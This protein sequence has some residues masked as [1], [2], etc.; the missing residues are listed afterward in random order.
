MRRCAYVLVPLLISSSALGDSRRNCGK[1]TGDAEVAACNEAIR[2]NPRDAISY[3]NL[4][5][6]HYAKK[7]H[8]Q[9]IADYSKAIEIN[10]RLSIGAN[11]P[12]VQAS[13]KEA[14]KRLGASE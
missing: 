4:G 10:P 13:G 7:E 9:A 11:D 5:V 3:Y 8:V 14:L 2:Q 12:E 6:A 1:M